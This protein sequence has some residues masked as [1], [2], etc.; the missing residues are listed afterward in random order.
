MNFTETAP[1]KCLE[2]RRIYSVQEYENYDP[3]RFPKNME[4]SI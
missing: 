1:E 4:L 3:Y 2:E